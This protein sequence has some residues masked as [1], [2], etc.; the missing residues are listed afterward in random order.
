MLLRSIA[1]AAH[2]ARGFVP[3]L[4]LPVDNDAGHCR[5]MTRG[6]RLPRGAVLQYRR[7]GEYD[8]PR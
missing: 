4:V 7:P 3:A 8:A 1:R 2:Q 5:F 6:L